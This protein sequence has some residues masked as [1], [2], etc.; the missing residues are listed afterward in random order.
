[1]GR[2]PGP[3]GAFFHRIEKRR[4]RN[5]AVV[6]TARKLVTIAWHVL[7][8]NEP[9]RYA[10]PRATAEKLAKLRI[11]ATGK[12]RQGGNP[13]GQGRP[14]AY[15][16]GVSSRGIPSLPEVYENEGLPPAKELDELPAAER[17]VLERT[18]TLPFVEKIQNR[19]RV[20]RTNAAQ[21]LRTGA[22]PAENTMGSTSGAPVRSAHEGEGPTPEGEPA[23][24]PIAPTPVSPG[25][26]PQ[27]T[28]RRDEAPAIA[29]A[30]GSR[31]D[32]AD[33]PE[34]RPRR[35]GPVRDLCRP[36]KK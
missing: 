15:G 14:A 6:A 23:A 19:S 20:P 5:V 32:N 3:L 7:K 29:H 11:E 35:P 9:Y 13:R 1:V 30:S 31:M 36:A 21:A 26:A 18:G 24:S 27:E 28:S 25:E 33:D 12:R 10:A 34:P 2:S 16:T 17:R 8:S 4:G 22:P